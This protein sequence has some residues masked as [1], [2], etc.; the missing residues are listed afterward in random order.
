MNE[1]FQTPNHKFLLAIRVPDKEDK[2]RFLGRTP[3]EA[4]GL[5]LFRH[6]TSRPPVPLRLICGGFTG[7]CPIGRYELIARYLIRALKARWRDQRAELGALLRAVRPGETAVDAGAN[8]GAYL[9]WLARAVGPGGKVLAYE[10][11]P[12]LAAYLRGVARAMR[13]RHVDIRESGLS[14]QSGMAPL[15]IPDGETSPGASFE[16]KPKVPGGVGRA[17]QCPLETLDN[18]L[19]SGPRVGAMKI[20]VEGHELALL[21]GA[22]EI[23]DRDHP[24]LLLECEAR[25]LTTHGVEDVFQFLNARGYRGRFFHPNGLKP[26]EEFDLGKHQKRDGERFWDAPDYCNNFL[27]EAST[28]KPPARAGG[29]PGKFRD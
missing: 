2:P 24:T 10:P 27:F 1:D 15:F 9:F 14:D 11:Q 5:H 8:K 3:R 20:D 19:A 13:W 12:L 6:A 22:K 28:A 26:L 4:A 21:R 29:K 18:A 16:P 25:H 7:H 17:I 23:L